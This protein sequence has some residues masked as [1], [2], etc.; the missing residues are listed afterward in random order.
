MM[1][2]V[3]TSSIVFMP[4]EFYRYVLMVVLSPT[5]VYLAIHSR[6]ADYSVLAVY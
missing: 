4:A 1:T 6:P 3:S 2:F 5:L